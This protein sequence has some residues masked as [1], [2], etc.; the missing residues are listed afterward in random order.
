[1]LT[2]LSEDVDQAWHVRLLDTEDYWNRLRDD[3]LGRLLD[4]RLAKGTKDDHKTLRAEFEE[5]MDRDRATF[6]APLEEIWP[7]AR[8]RLRDGGDHRI[9][10]IRD[11]GAA[12]GGFGGA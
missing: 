4:H 1:M 12:C 9:D 11:S 10:G 6:G 8:A 7:P 2:V 3:I 5:V